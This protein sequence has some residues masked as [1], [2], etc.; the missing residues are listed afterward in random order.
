[1]IAYAGDKLTIAVTY[2]DDEKYGLISDPI[3]ILQEVSDAEN[4]FLQ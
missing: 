3:V 4:P 1:M 2:P